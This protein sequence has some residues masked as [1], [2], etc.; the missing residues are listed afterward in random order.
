MPRAALLMRMSMRSVESVIFLAMAAVWDQ[1]LRSHSSQVTF[2]AASGP[3]SSL[4][5]ASA[6]STTSLET[7]MMK[8]LEMLCERREWVQP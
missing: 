4:M 5:A 2:L 1:S 8:S 7:E 6:P 3:S